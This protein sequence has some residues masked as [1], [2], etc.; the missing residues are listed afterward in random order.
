MWTCEI[1]KT[2]MP[3][4]DSVCS[5]C[6]YH[7]EA[8]AAARAQGTRL[9]FTLVR[10]RRGPVFSVEALGGEISREQSKIAPDIFEQEDTVSAPHCE[11]TCPDGRWMITDLGSTNGT[12]INSAPV[13]RLMATPLP[14]P[15]RLRMGELLWMVTEELITPPEDTKDTEIVPERWVIVCPNTRQEYPV[16][17]PDARLMECTCCQGKMRQRISARRPVKR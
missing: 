10:P 5:M 9:V 7:N 3:D 13:P 17:G 1:C 4:T 15:C 6:G 12:D 2:E 8:V 14:L 16:E 11:L